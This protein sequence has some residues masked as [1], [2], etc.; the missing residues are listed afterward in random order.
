MRLEH[1]QPELSLDK[2]IPKPPYEMLGLLVVVD[3]VVFVRR[4]VVLPTFG[5]GLF[6]L[7]MLSVVLR[8]SD[9]DAFARYWERAGGD[10]V[11]LLSAIE[12]GPGREWILESIEG[13]E[14]GRRA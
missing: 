9:A 1:L 7:E 12:A 3:S 4:R 5:Q 6:G 2:R 13:F 11:V 10:D 8:P 14:E